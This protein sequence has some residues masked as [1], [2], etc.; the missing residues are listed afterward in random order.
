MSTL[1]GREP[2]LGR[3]EVAREARDLGQGD[4]GAYLHE[5]VA[6]PS[7]VLQGSF[8]GI[9]GSLGLASVDERL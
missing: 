2:F 9:V 1:S 3:V 5:H 7:A 8:G 6:A 4:D